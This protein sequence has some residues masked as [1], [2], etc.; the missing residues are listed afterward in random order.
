MASRVVGKNLQLNHYILKSWEEYSRKRSRGG[1][2]AGS[3]AERLSRY[4]DENYFYGREPFLNRVEDIAIL[5]FL[6]KVKEEMSRL[7]IGTDPAQVS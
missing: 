7:G 1:V 6:D 2:L 5:A 3:V 4:Q